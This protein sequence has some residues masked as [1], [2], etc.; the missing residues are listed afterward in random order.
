MKAVQA[1]KLEAIQALISH[2]ADVNLQD[3]RGNSSV[4]FFVEGN[5]EKE[6]VIL[7]ELLRA[8]A[9]INITNFKGETPLMLAAQYGN[10]KML[11]L[12]IS[13]GASKDSLNHLGETVLFTLARKNNVLAIKYFLSLGVN[14]SMRNSQGKVYS[15]YLEKKI[16]SRN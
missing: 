5:T 8:G 7:N 4:H 16:F 10:L 14:A 12:L 13:L 1:G 11:K 15:D 6:E 2:G 3:V 9:K